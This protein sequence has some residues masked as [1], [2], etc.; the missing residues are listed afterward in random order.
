M[1]RTLRLVAFGNAVTMVVLAALAGCSSAPKSTEPPQPEPPPPVT[2]QEV[3]PKDRAQIH[4]DLGAGY[5]ERGQMDVAL[6]ELNEA[7]KLDPSNAKTYNVFGLVYATMGENAKAEQNFQRALALAPLDSE[8]H[9][10]W[11]W[12]LCSNGRA[13]ESIAEFEQALRN[14]LYRTP[15]IALINAAR[16]SASFGDT[17]A[18]QAYY[19]RALAASPGNPAAAYGLAFLA[20][21]DARLAEARSFMRPVMQ[22]ANPPPEALYL[23]MCIERKLGDRQAE[24]SYTSQ[25][26]N[27]YPDSAESKAIAT[28]SCE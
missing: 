25:L 6:E 24:L 1:T 4:I 7:M 9:H 14:P 3:S 10:N 21:R 8:I 19:R 20:F 18:A 17:A 26:R 28:G 27:R 2:K 5:Y 11:G 16:C 15:E 22:Q 23:G 13:R 12:Y